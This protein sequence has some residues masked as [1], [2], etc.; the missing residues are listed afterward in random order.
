MHIYFKIYCS[1]ETLIFN[2][3]IWLAFYVP[4]WQIKIFFSK[5]FA[6]RIIEAISCNMKSLIWLVELSYIF[7]GQG[8]VWFSLLFHRW[9]CLKV[10]CKIP[11]VWF[12]FLLTQLTFSLIR[13]GGQV[14]HVICLMHT[15][16]YKTTT[17]YHFLAWCL[18]NNAG[19]YYIY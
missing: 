19:V 5:R 18:V 15:S 2:V 14:A 11:I 8:N 17:F 7:T 16:G 1:V 4:I 10:D 9:S 6:K 3:L 12:S 13:F